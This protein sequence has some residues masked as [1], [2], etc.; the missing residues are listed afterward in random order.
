MKSYKEVLG[1]EYTQ[2]SLHK[3][4]FPGQA[5]VCWQ[6]TQIQYQTKE[7]FVWNI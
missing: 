7:I 4:L 3:H 2:D 6:A 1:G 5:Q